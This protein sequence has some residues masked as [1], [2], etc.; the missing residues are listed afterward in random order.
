MSAVCLV[1]LGTALAIACSR[2]ELEHPQLVRSADAICRDTTSQLQA[3]RPVQ[4]A[5]REQVGASLQ[6]IANITE[7]QLIRLRKLRP[8]RNDKEPYQRWLGAV[9]QAAVHL[10]SAAEALRRGDAIAAQA[11]VRS[12]SDSSKRAEA[13]ARSLGLEACR[14]VTA[15]P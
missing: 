7:A 15:S 8:V 1:A 4:A 13:E 12:A 6:E 14:S 9:D 10:A 3:V 11:S 5:S 2:S